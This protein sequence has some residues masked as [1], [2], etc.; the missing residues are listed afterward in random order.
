MQDEK[1]ETV[2]VA[3]FYYE[4]FVQ[5]TKIILD[6]AIKKARLTNARVA[7]RVGISERQMRDYLN[8]DKEDM[9]PMPCLFR[10][11]GETITPPWQYHRSILAKIEDP[12][13][14]RAAQDCEVGSPEYEVLRNCAALKLLIR[15]TITERNLSVVDTASKAGI[16]PGKMYKIT[17]PKTLV[18]PNWEEWFR[19]CEVLK[20]PEWKGFCGFLAEEAYRIVRPQAANE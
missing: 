12:L 4:E 6:A 19:L 5:T 7:E 16:L 15:Q 10:I 13:P 2:P 17:S 14:F 18:L 20:F 1:T 3:D 8:L 11:C 9:P